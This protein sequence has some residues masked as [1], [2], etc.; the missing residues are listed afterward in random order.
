MRVK[1]D[2]PNVGI[3]IECL[4]DIEIDD[5]RKWIPDKVV[6]MIFNEDK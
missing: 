3:N 6:G 2:N 4:N 1:D 5:L